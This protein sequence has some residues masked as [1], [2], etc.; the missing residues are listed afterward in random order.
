MWEV[1]E[2]D[3]KP[4]CALLIVSSRETNTILR[5][6]WWPQAAKQEGDEIFKRFCVMY[7]RNLMIPRMLEVSLSGGGVLC[8]G[9]AAWSMVK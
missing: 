6:K 2:G 3:V 4:F 1:D 9:R 8:L 5:D 7:G